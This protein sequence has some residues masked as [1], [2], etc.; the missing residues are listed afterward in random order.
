M[1]PSPQAPE[2]ILHSGRV[3]TAHE[4]GR[5]LEAIAIGGKRILAVGS[6]RETLSLAGSGTR[7]HNLGGRCVFPGLID[8]HN[9]LSIVGQGSLGCDIDGIESIDDLLDAIRAAALTNERDAWIMTKQVGESVISHELREGRYPYRWELDR[10]APNHPVCVRSFHVGILNTKALERLGITRSTPSPTGG[11][12]GRQSQP[13]GELDGRF[14]EAA[15]TSLI[16]RRLP[17]PSLERRVSA[18]ESAARK[19]NRLGIT[20]V[21]E[22]GIPWKTWEAYDAAQWANRLSVKVSAHLHVG[23]GS[24]VN[25]DEEAIREVGR[26]RRDSSSGERA[27]LDGVKVFIDGGVALGT[28]YFTRPYRTAYGEWT[29]GLQVT[30]ADRLRNIVRR[31]LENGVQISQHASGDAA[32]THVLDAYDAVADATA[33]RAG[34]FILVHCQ[35]P[36][37]QDIDRI[38][39]RGVLVAAQTLFLYNMGQGY[40]Q[41]HG[42]RGKSA[43]PLRKFL[44]RGCHIG[45]GSDAPVNQFHPFMGA[46][47]AMNRVCKATGERMDAEQAITRSEALRCYTERNAWFGS[48]EASTGRL[49]AGAAADLAILDS[50]PDLSSIETALATRVACT[51]VD[52]E[53][54][55]GSLTPT[56]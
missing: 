4:P 11:E 13:D 30:P 29:N 24:Q 20:Q 23:P 15:W 16:E 53:V 27:T 25:D 42:E 31:C 43:V 10:A 34:R 12:I 19:L 2:W 49:V 9:H 39:D 55:H 21:C 36:V 22:H 7:K 5:T 40:T 52:G 47:H 38:A 3:H 1:T 45:L 41:Y 14:Y 54:V 8:S 26:I 35:F 33:I 44:D 28:A 32:I 56:D 18:I 17:E 48:R 46:W 51:I 37:E 50:D 6:D